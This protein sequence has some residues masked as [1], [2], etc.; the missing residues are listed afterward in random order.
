MDHRYGI[1]SCLDTEASRAAL[2]ETVAQAGFRR[3]ELLAEP[4]CLD[5]WVQDPQALR[6]DLTRFGF[7]AV[8]VHSPKAGWQN[9]AP[10]EAVRRASVQATAACFEPARAIGAELMIIHPTSGDVTYTRSESA[11]HRARAMRSLAELA[12]HAARVGLR[13]A[14]ENLPARGA[15]RPGVRVED[16]LDM[17]IGLGD[18]VGVCLDVG[19]AQA[20]G[21][22]PEGEIVA[23]GP[24]LFAVHLHDND[25]SGEDTH[26]FPGRGSLNWEA[27]VRTLDR[28]AYD[29]GRVFE[30][31]RLVE[32]VAFTLTQLADLVRTWGR[33]REGVSG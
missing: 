11:A 31:P 16:I 9:N 23:A 24:K 3:L 27:I 20:S 13:L 14:A 21:L 7:R 19:H 5:G 6:R 26:A 12:E 4:D 33:W 2:L 17:I 22:S 28:A 10:N 8:T 15:A 30:V 25:G 32:G 1:S 29:G 18:H